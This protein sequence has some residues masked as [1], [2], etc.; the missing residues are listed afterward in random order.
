MRYATSPP[1]N[2]SDVQADP[3]QLGSQQFEA[4]ARRIAW[5]NIGQNN[6]PGIAP[7]GLTDRG[8]FAKLGP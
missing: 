2:T 4:A 6:A 8:E 3:A 5:D 1:S 7:L